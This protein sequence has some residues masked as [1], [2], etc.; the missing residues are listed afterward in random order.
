MAD[1]LLNVGDTFFVYEHFK[2]YK[3]SIQT[4]D[5]GFKVVVKPE[6]VLK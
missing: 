1:R 4:D 3:F 2:I 6:G 5:T